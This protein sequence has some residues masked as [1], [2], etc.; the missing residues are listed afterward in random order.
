[1]AATVT[2]GIT[3]ATTGGATPTTGIAST[4]ASI[5]STPT[6]IATATAGIAATASMIAAAA[7]EGTITPLVSTIAVVATEAMAAPAM[8]VSPAKPRADA[9][10][11]A[12]VEIF[13]PP[14]TGRRT[15]IGCVIV[16]SIG[17]YGH[18]SNFDSRTSNLDPDTDLCGSGHWRKC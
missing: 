13:R 8:V 12:V 18:R 9:E 14:E 10:E 5:P 3:A 15:G 6:G 11:D 16:I 1:V 2:T 4:A 17:T 7:G